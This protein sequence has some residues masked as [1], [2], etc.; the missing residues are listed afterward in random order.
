MM[1]RTHLSITPKFWL[2][3]CLI[4][5]ISFCPSLA[6]SPTANFLPY[7]NMFYPIRVG[8][9]CKTNR[10]FIAVWSPGYVFVNN[11]PVFELKPGKP[12]QL[13]MS[14]ITDLSSGQSFILPTT[15]RTQIAANDYRVWA[16]NKWWRGSLEIINFGSKFTVINLLDLEDY[17]RGVVPS[18]MPYSWNIEALKAQAVAARSYAIAHSGKGSKWKSE[19][20]DIVPDVRDQ[21]YKG[22]GNEHD[23]SSRAVME[24]NGVIL[25]NAGKVKP[26]FYRAWVGNSNENLNIRQ[27]CV[28]CQKL[29]SLTGVPK[30]VG[31]TPKQWDANGNVNDIQIM[32]TKKSRDVYG[33]ALAKILNLPTAGILDVKQSGNNWLFTCRGPG[34]GALGLSQHGA[35]ML[36]NNGWKYEQILQHY[37]QDN[38]GQLRLGNI[39]NNFNLT[40]NFPQSYSYSSITK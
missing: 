25:K 36:A 39:N 23:S 26:G 5:I 12:Y 1:S 33:L 37:Y 31:V 38:D 22:L 28:N 10:A 16:N 32:G 20:F 35:N 34:N 13:S 7:P 15:A 30:I 27:I 29:E 14:K 2:M 18:E 19:G 9:M 3:L 11:V 8:L 17:L 21:A 4:Q 6:K 24:T 40:S